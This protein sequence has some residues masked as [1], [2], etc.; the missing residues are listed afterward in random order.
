MG[1]SSSSE[2]QNE[3]LT[4]ILDNLGAF[5]QHCV[6]A[7]LIEDYYNKG[8]PS[9]EVEL[10][11]DGSSSSSSGGISLVVSLENAT[12]SFTRPADPLP[13]DFAFH[14]YEV[15]GALNLSA[16]KAS[17]ADQFTVT[18]EVDPNHIGPVTFQVNAE[19][20]KYE[21]LRRRYTLHGPGDY[22]DSS[23]IGLKRLNDRPRL[24]QTYINYLAGWLATFWDLYEQE[25]DELIPEFYPPFPGAEFDPFQH[26][27]DRLVNENPTAQNL[28]R[29]LD[30]E[31][32]QQIGIDGRNFLGVTRE[33]WDCMMHPKLSRQDYFSQELEA[34][35][36]RDSAVT[37]VVAFNA[38]GNRIGY[39]VQSVDPEAGTVTIVEDAF[40]PGPP[41]TLSFDDIYTISGPGVQDW[42]RL[43]KTLPREPSF[44][45]TRDISRWL[46][47][48]EY[49][50][51]GS[52][53]CRS[54]S[55][56]AVLYLRSQLSQT[57]PNAKV[58]HM[59]VPGHAVVYVDLG[60]CWEG[61]QNC[62]AQCCSGNFVYEPQSGQTW[63][64]GPTFEDDATLY[65]SLRQPDRDFNIKEYKIAQN[66][67]G[68]DMNFGKNRIDWSQFPEEVS[69]I[70][71]IICDCVLGADYVFSPNSNESALRQKCLDG[72]L[73]DWLKDNLAPGP[74]KTTLADPNFARPLSCQRYA[75]SG[76]G[77]QPISPELSALLG[78]GM[79][80]DECQ[81]YCHQYFGCDGS[82]CTGEWSTSPFL[83]H[84]HPSLQDCLDYS[85]CPQPD[86]TRTL[87][88][89]DDH[90]WFGGRLGEKRAPEPK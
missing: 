17:G 82:N 74:D 87:R 67:D 73:E 39:K 2:A 6:D 26:A 47:F 30:L 50:P 53:D 35:R 24:S 83:T 15:Q 48:D 64:G 7:A 85:N 77:C 62:D 31:P 32:S 12:R 69:R 33:A 5:K 45:R 86:K 14:F 13:D 19:S 42:A 27:R 60:G 57:C 1:S 49:P 4:L 41:V 23:R 44:W 80:E 52:F 66:P 89:G 58:S 10:S 70:R 55:A 28:I 68:S 37:F 88:F 25:Q 76:Q 90:E 81:S 71:N 72:T 40:S 78:G 21:T 63:D 56:A 51:D 29:T 22:R 18:A 3:V 84:T 65:A 75:C 11:P 8:A 46:G 20:L 34:A 59:Q 79:S 16:A 38:G 36:Q 61:Q 54:F 9:A 43:Y